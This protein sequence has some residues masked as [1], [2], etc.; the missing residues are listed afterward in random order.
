MVDFD[1]H[2]AWDDGD[3]V[4]ATILEKTVPTRKRKHTAAAQAD[5]TDDGATATGMGGDAAGAPVDAHGS[6]TKK[7]R[8][9]GSRATARDAQKH[10]QRM[11]KFG[12]SRGNT[13]RSGPGSVE[14]R[15]AEDW[16]EW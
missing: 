5:D 8:R 13:P 16:A 3:E 14:G 6:A 11:A 7:R 2:S 10:S 4:T 9:Q 12:A 1:P 15:P